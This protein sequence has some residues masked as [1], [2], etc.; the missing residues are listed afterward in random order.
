VVRDAAVLPITTTFGEKWFP[1][2]RAALPEAV[3]IGIDER[4]CRAVGVGSV[5]NALEPAVSRCTFPGKR[6]VHCVSGALDGI[7][8]PCARSD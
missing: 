1:S 4:T 6:S 3:L 2:A 7:P 8:Q 5:A